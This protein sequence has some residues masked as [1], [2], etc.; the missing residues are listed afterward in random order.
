MTW[1]AHRVT[2]EALEG[3]QHLP[4]GPS[5]QRGWPGQE[6]EGGLQPCAAEAEGAGVFRASGPERFPTGH[7][8]KGRLRCQGNIGNR[9]RGGGG[10]FS[11]LPARG[12]A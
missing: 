5:L 7:V 10:G 1:K 4:A 9:Q 2:P 3:R 11:F 12:R 8:R 6:E